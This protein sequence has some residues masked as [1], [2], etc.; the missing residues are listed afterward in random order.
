MLRLLCT[1]E[2][3]G[4]LQTCYEAAGMKQTTVTDSTGVQE[5]HLYERMKRN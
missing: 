3:E 5:V 4:N 1:Y 2:M